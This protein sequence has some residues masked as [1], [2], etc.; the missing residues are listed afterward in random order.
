MKLN[1]RSLTWRLYAVA[2]LLGLT[3]VGVA[4]YA[5]ISMGEVEATTQ[6]T[7]QTSVPQLSRMSRMELN[8]TRASLQ[9]RHAILARNTQERDAS[10]SDIARKR[11]LIEDD[12]RAYERDLSTERGRQLYQGLPVKF[13]EFWKVA[14]AN[15][16]LILDDRKS[17]AFAYL[18]DRTVPIRNEVLAVLGPA[19]TYQTELL[20]AAL[21]DAGQRTDHFESVLEGMVGA[22]VSL[23]AVSIW[24]VGRQMRLRVGTAQQV[25]ERVRDGDLTVSMIEQHGDEF[26]PLLQALQQMQTGL[27]ALVGQVRAN[28]EHVASAS[29]EIAS[30]NADLSQRTEHQSASLQQA[31]ASMESINNAASRNAES[32]AQASRLAADASG[33][34]RQGGTVVEGM[35]ETMKAIDAASRQVVDIIGV[36]DGIAFQTN[37]LALNAAVEAARAGEQGRGFAVVASEVR[38]LAQRSAEAA[39][40]IKGLIQTSVERIESGS[41]Q[42]SMV[43]KTMEEV[44]GAIARVD[45]IVAEINAAS[46]EQMRGIAQVTQAVSQMEQATQQNAALVEQSAAASESMRSQA[47]A[48]VQ[49]VSS[50]RTAEA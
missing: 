23:L 12:L 46:S 28:A 15:V 33:T 4:I 41:S 36:I 49:T 39:K 10:L 9:L 32:A 21:D 8:L 1:F 22:C 45:H 24:W 38:A 6:R 25:A 5:R 14:E 16:Q 31:A 43:G 2:A 34:A 44:V 29:T 20:E 26:S 48:L 27:S 18:A 3:L 11:Q 40:Q 30:G 47:G 7:K 35:M 42:A 37:I 13:A 17:E 19:V 50:F